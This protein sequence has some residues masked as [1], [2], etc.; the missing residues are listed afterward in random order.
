MAG[1]D[2]RMNRPIV[3]KVG[4]NVVTRK[5]ETSDRPSLDVNLL[6]DLAKEISKFI[7]ENHRRVILVSSGAVAAGR[8]VMKLEAS[9]GKTTAGKQAFASVGQPRL[10][11]EYEKAFLVATPHRI[12]SQML[13]TAN[14]LEREDG[15]RNILDMLEVLPRDIVTIVN[16]NDTVATEELNLG[17]NDQLAA[18]IALLVHAEILVLLT[19][20]DGVFDKDPKQHQNARLIHELPFDDLT[21]AF[22]ESCGAGKSSNGTG[23]MASKLRAARMA[24]AENIQ[25]F[26]ANG[27]RPGVLSAIAEGRP[28]GTEITPRHTA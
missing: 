5:H 9:V 14:D 19:D 4:T 8:E 1:L 17:D 2:T 12:T 21:D 23:G 15:R 3:V 24:S 27:K 7:E 18:K 22:I 26:I 16:E 13:L 6:R 28:V 20:T 11:A 10:M 25:T